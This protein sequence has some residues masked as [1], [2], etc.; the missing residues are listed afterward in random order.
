MDKQH[1]IA[2]A[3]SFSGIGLHTGNLTTITFKPAEP[4][5]GVRFY[6]VDLPGCPEIKAEQNLATLARRVL[7]GAIRRPLAGPFHIGEVR[8]VGAIKF[9]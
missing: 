4:D 6:R 1:T 8:S 7:H 5:T 3:T 2:K 9:Q